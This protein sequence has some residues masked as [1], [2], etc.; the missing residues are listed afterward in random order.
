M[1]ADNKVKKD[2]ADLK[3]MFIKAEEMRLTGSNKGRGRAV[4]LAEANDDELWEEARNRGVEMFL[5]EPRP[6]FPRY[7]GYQ[8]GHP[9]G[10]YQRE[11]DTQER[12][13]SSGNQYH[14]QRPTQ[15]IQPAELEQIL[16]RVT[17][18]LAKAMQGKPR[19]T[20][21]NCYNCGKEGHY[22]NECP[23]PSRKAI[24]ARTPAEKE[25]F[26]SQG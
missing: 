5:S 4:Y 17:E 22:A 9:Q 3:K 15:G 25:N 21:E 10:G 19:P 12:M 2:I 20:G 11:P 16:V 13:Q 1:S 6:R 23:T 26:P 18:S 24:Q 7:G 8:A 14:Q